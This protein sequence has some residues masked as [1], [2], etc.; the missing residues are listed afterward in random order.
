MV[1]IGLISDVHATPGPLAEALSIFAK[2]GVEQVFCAGDIAGYMD[3]LEQTIALLVENNCLT[4]MGNH[5]Q[6]YLAQYQQAHEDKP[7]D[8][9]AAFLKQLPAFYE[10]IIEGKTVYMVHAEPPDVCNGGIK[11]LDKNGEL[12]ADR[13]EQWKQ[14]LQF[15]NYDV[16]VVGHTHQV[17]AEFIGNT[18]VVNPGSSAFNNSCAILRLPQMTVEMLSLSGKPIIKTWNWGQHVIYAK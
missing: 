3:Q 2:A 7:D 5:D 9:S 12:L 16:L 11:L 13:V 6:L 10:T 8:S 17:F 4:I 1:S 15:F 18:L 14:K